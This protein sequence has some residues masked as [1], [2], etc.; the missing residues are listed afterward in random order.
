[1]TIRKMSND[2]KKFNFYKS[3][4]DPATGTIVRSVEFPKSPNRWSYF[5]LI[6]AAAR[7]LHIDMY[8]QKGKDFALSWHRKYGTVSSQKTK[9]EPTKYYGR[10]SEWRYLK[11]FSPVPE[12]IDVKITNWCNGPGGEL[13]SYCLT[14]E[15]RVLTSG[16]K[17]VPISE[18]QVG[19]DLWGIDEYQIGTALPR[20]IHKSKV[21][22]KWETVQPEYVVELENGRTIRAS[23]NHL[24]LTRRG[25]WLTTDKLQ[26]GFNLLSI[27]LWDSAPY[28]A[29]D[30]DYVKGYIAGVSWGDGTFNWDLAE[31]QVYWRVAL[32]DL[33]ILRRIEEFLPKLG[34]SCPGI[35]PFDGGPMALNTEMYQVEVRQ[36]AGLSVLREILESAKC[37][38]SSLS[39]EFKRGFVAGFFDA[40]GSL[41]TSNLRVGQKNHMWALELMACVLREY[42]F[43]FEEES[44]S[45]ENEVVTFRLNGHSYWDRLKFF[46]KFQPACLR[47]YENLEGTKFFRAAV[48]VKS[49]TATGNWVKMVDITTS[50]STFFAEGI[51]TH[52]CYMGSDTKGKHAPKELLEAIFKGLKKAPYQIAFGGGEP[53]SHPDFDW[54]LQYTR[55]QGTVPNYTTAG[56]IMRPEI[57]KA[58][59]LYCGGVALSYHAFKGIE[60]F[61]ERYTKWR[62]ALEPH[63]QLNVHL[64]FDDNVAENLMDLV[65]SGLEDLNIVLLAYYPDVGRSNMSG[66][67]SKGTY[68]VRLPEAMEE[69]RIFGHRVAFSEGLL[70]YF[71]S[72]QFYE[73]DTRFAMQQEALF[74]CYV[75]DK[76][77]VSHS[78]FSPP[79]EESP[80][81]YTTKF[82]NIWNKLDLPRGEWREELSICGECKYKDQCHICAPEHAML[83]NFALHNK[84]PAIDVAPRKRS[85]P[86]VG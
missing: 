20:Y 2:F 49:V 63:V 39:A 42:D 5:S 65:E 81:I 11:P 22:H 15:T 41:E 48:L 82:Q 72:H 36:T 7:A 46:G 3:S 38:I 27:P 26:K 52:N 16:G 73:V 8:S 84:S 47:K 6:D 75:D 44:F 30:L 18:L 69:A 37:D 54:F 43:N 21:L 79:T 56:H 29:F 33:D 34:V 71:L 50:T 31:G 9:G 24:W 35:R 51:A 83:C 66:I 53:T 78:S 23:P 67:P 10:S 1:M 17:H 74:S 60:W 68:Q 55:E 14:P 40:E 77:F 57:I 64:I 19:D 59:N 12:T 62:A 70:P 28:S 58:T 4:F 25:G 76:G 80:N 13:C 85:L 32:K 86:V 61:K 45:Q